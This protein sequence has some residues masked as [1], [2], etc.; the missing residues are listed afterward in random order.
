MWNLLGLGD[1]VLTHCRCP[2]VLRDY[3]DLVAEGTVGRVRVE[4]SA[5]P[6]A[7][8]SDVLW[9]LNHMDSLRSAVASADTLVLFVGANDFD[10]VFDAV[11]GGRSP[12]LFDAV[13]DRLH[14]NMSAILGIVRQLHGPGIQV[15]VCGY[16]NDFK[17]GAVARQDYSPARRRAAAAAT[18]A[19]NSAL[20]QAAQAAGA[21]WVPSTA[22]FADPDSSGVLAP[23][24]DHL[25]GTGARLIAAALIAAPPPT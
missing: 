8:S 9:A 13:A 5:A 14:A 22:A 1:S 2:G 15:L 25:S 24:G 20:R 21:V 7:T 17:D 12:M 11:A 19:T 18:V 3:A 16:W 10:D 6:G 4:N 23:D